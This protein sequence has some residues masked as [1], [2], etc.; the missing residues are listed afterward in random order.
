MEYIGKSVE[1]GN[2]LAAVEK[3]GNPIADIAVRDAY[4]QHE[5]GL[6]MIPK[7]GPDFNVRMGSVRVELEENGNPVEGEYIPGSLNYNFTP[8]EVN[9]FM[10][11][12]ASINMRYTPDQKIDTYL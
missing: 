7:V 10:R 1:D 12:Y 3:G 5:F 11:Q 4:P 6:G 9:I 2:R 8:A